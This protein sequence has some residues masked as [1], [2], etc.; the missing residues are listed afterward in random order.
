MHKGE[1]ETEEVDE[2][3]DEDLIDLESAISEDTAQIQAAMS[4]VVNSRVG[5]PVMTPKGKGVVSGIV[6]QAKTT[7]DGKA[8]PYVHSV[9]VKMG[10][11]TVHV[12]PANQ[13][14]LFKGK[15]PSGPLLPKS[16]SSTAINNADKAVAA[17]GGKESGTKPK[18]SSMWKA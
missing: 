2:A 6:K 5:K 12:M 3:A 17:Q 10:D 1:P 13:V 7:A 4:G 16:V 9:T 15:K 8:G 14:K 11:N 18:T